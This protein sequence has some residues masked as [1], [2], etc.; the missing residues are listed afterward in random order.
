MG[1]GHLRCF[2]WFLHL[3]KMSAENQEDS[4]LYSLSMGTLVG[5]GS[6]RIICTIVMFTFCNLNSEAVLL[7]RKYYENSLLFP[8]VKSKTFLFF[9]FFFPPKI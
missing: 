2:H 4:L 1:M 8:N 5:G 3:I 9:F 7:W 6:V